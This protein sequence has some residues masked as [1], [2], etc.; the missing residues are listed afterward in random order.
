LKNKDH[1]SLLLQLNNIKRKKNGESLANC[2]PITIAKSLEQMK[3]FHHK[4]KMQILIIS[5][6]F[7]LICQLNAQQLLGGK[8][9]VQDVKERRTWANKA[10]NELEKASNSIFAR[11]IVEIVNVETQVVAGIIYHVTLKLAFTGCRKG[12]KIEKLGACEETTLQ[13]KR[14]V[15]LA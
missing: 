8:Q 5:L 9:E 4:V 3:K 13:E 11:K 14:R 6:F 10:L 12:V 1:L 15:Y 2:P 7:T